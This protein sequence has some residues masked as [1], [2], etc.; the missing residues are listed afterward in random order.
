L[1]L[2][3]LPVCVPRLAYSGPGG[4]RTHSIRES[5]SRW[6][7]DCLPSHLCRSARR[8]SRTPRHPGLSRVAQ[9]VG[10]AG[11]PHLLLRPGPPPVTAARLFSFQPPVRQA[12][13]PH[14]LHTAR[15]A[16]KPDLRQSARLDLNQRSPPSRGGGHSGLPHTLRAGE[17]APAT[18][19]AVAVRVAEALV[20][21]TG[22]EP[23]THRSGICCSYQLS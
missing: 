9:P 4:S 23:V 21:T 19:K 7:A 1:S 17:L 8:G 12:F 16:G 20:L 3:A 2:A 10:V 11:R 6:S 15:Q 5:D 13:Q 22:F 14:T 18:E